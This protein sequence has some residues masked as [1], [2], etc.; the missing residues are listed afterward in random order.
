M[1]DAL[2]PAVPAGEHRF[3]RAPARGGKNET[4]NS[5]SSAPQWVHRVHVRE[6]G[7][8]QNGGL[9]HGLGPLFT[10]AVPMGHATELCW[11]GENTSQLASARGCHRS[12]YK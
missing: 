5:S 12:P 4:G 10:V 6:R 3:S 2:S 11:L 7:G 1:R 9:R 8:V